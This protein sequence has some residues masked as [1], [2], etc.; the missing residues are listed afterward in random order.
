MKKATEKKNLF[1]PFAKSIDPY[2]II[3][4]SLKKPIQV[5][6]SFAD[7]KFRKKVIKNPPKTIS[8]LSLNSAPLYGS[9]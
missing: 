7:K 5:R 3:V 1:T 6:N 4:N 2:L 8:F 9:F